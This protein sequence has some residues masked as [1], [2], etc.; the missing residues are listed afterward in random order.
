ME[1]AVYYGAS[2]LRDAVYCATGDRNDVV[3]IDSSEP[4]SSA[5]VRMA[6]AFALEGA[7]TRYDIS[8]VSEPAGS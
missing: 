4:S 3:Q 2:G 1:Q 5:P 8:N 6:V 7:D